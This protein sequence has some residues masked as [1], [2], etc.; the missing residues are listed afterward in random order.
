MKKALLII[1]CLLNLLLL[2][3]KS[4]SADTSCT[5]SVSP[6]TGLL[7]TSSVTV[8]LKISFGLVGAQGGEYSILLDKQAKTLPNGTNKTNTDVAITLTNLPAGKH[9]VEGENQTCNKMFNFVSQTCGKCDSEFEV[10]QSIGGN[11][12]ECEFPAIYQYDPDPARKVCCK[13]GDPSCTTRQPPVCKSTKVWK[14][15][16]QK[17][18]CEAIKNNPWEKEECNAC[19]EGSQNPLP[20]G[21]DYTNKTGS[22]TALG[23][24]PT[25][26]D[27]LM[28]WLL[29]RAINIAGGVAFLL[30]IFG[31]SKIITSSGN[32]EGLNE[33]KE[34][35]FAALA[36][37][38]FIVLSMVLLKIIAGDILQIP[39]FI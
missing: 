8:N 27:Q 25:K 13:I 32:P 28:A 7:P 19:L 5:I 6:N 30:I 21:T 31:T 9:T 35:I 17:L 36:G 10:L 33:G 29:E 14:V 16:A 22:W 4:A 3:S 37:L 11:C 1:F 39:G 23:C 24:I 26:P 38:L 15:A 20:K 34:I 12:T 18:S 2:S